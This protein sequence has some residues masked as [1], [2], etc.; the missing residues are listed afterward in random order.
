[1][2]HS[3]RQIK[4]V[5]LDIDGTLI[6]SNG[7]HASGWVDAFADDGRDIPHEE[8][9]RLIGM[10][11]ERILKHYGIEPESERGE[12]LRD[13]A[14]RYFKERY[15]PSIPA[16]PEV[17]ELLERMKADGLK[18][19]V[20]TSAGSDL[21]EGLLERAGVTDLIDEATSAS[22][23]KHSK[24]APDIVLAALEKSGRDADEVLMLGDTPYDVEASQRAGVPIVAVLCGG[25]DAESLEGA[26]AIYEDPADLLARYDSSPFVQGTAP[27]GGG[28]VFVV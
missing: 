13:L 3:S 24:P 16:F 5:L 11:G 23:V 25:W 28:T 12:R 4:A 18:L 2:P 26:D 1:M 14:G 10:G 8:I 9:R 20:A 15:M 27:Q 22:D 7:A 19:V 17:R 21:L 6:D